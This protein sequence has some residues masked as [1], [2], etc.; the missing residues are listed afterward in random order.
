MQSIKLKALSRKQKN[1]SI[2]NL[3]KHSNQVL[4]RNIL[5]AADATPKR[6]INSLLHEEE[7]TPISKG[8]Y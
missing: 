8:F 3:W 4:N 2:P 7:E 1:I 5:A 6:I